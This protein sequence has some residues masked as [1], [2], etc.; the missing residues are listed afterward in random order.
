MRHTDLEDI[1]IRG[2]TLDQVPRDFKRPNVI[3]W[4]AIG[5]VW[6]VRELR[7]PERSR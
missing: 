4:S 5:G 3:P 7:A 2:A 1:E 6:G